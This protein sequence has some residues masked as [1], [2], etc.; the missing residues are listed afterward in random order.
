VPAVREEVVRQPAERRVPGVRE[1]VVRPP[2]ERRV[3]AVREE[4]VRPPSERRVPAVREEVV[5]PP[6]QARMPAAHE[7]SVHAQRAPQP[8]QP[9]QQAR[10]VTSR[11]TS[12]MQS[13][14]EEPARTPHKPP[15]PAA[16]PTVA[17]TESAQEPA[18]PSLRDRRKPRKLSSAL[19]RLDRELKQ[20]RTQPSSSPVEQQASATPSPGAGQAGAGS[21][22]SYAR[23]R[24]DQLRRMRAA[25][26]NQ[27]QQQAQ[28]SKAPAPANGQDLLRAAQKELRDQQFARAHD[29]MR[30]ACE[31]EP[32]N[33]IYSM[34]CMYAALRANALKQE[35]VNKL[36]AMLR[37]KISDDQHKAFAYNALGH[38]ALAEKKDEA[39]ERFF[40][41]A[42]E[43]DKNN[44]DAERYVRIIA[45][46]RKTAAEQ[47][48]ANKIFGIEIGLKKSQ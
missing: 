25:T 12:G 39:A 20:L 38:I 33:Q 28:A 24:V 32:D 35:D 13:A 8:A 10:G 26:L 37:D 19:K 47:E 6:S 46:K 48:K 11:S 31:A 18:S 42:V 5:R 27:Q 29:L 1:E 15:M 16:Q 3:P 44:K 43:L 17:K 41:K 22:Q 23:A 14:R 7:P 36:R 2:S 40:Q 4:V 45:V 9:M 30:K 21:Q 34:Y